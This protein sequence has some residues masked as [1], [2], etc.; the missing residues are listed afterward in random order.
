MKKY[1]STVGEALSMVYSNKK[2]YLLSSLLAVFI[3]VLF[4]FL[5]NI[6]SLSSVLNLKLGAKVILDVLLSAAGMIIVTSGTFY[7]LLIVLVSILSAVTLSTLFYK[8]RGLSANKTNKGNLTG[9]LG[10]FGGALS[11][12]CSACSA[13]LISLLGVSGGLAVFPLKGLELT[14]LAIILLSISLYTSSR[15]IVSK[16]CGVK[17]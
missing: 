2:Y 14:F 6:P 8:L 10:V 11:S 16:T 13:T 3:F 1:F 5:N 4:I 12:G 9:F 17:K 7:F 15:S